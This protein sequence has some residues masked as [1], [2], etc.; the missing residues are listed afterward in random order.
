[1]VRSMIQNIIRFTLVFAVAGTALLSSE[2]LVL[3]RG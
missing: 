3:R 1:V 2:V